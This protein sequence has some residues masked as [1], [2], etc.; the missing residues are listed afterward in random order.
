MSGL[1]LFNFFV[2]PYDL[3]RLVLIPGINS[4]KHET[5]RHDRM[6]KTFYVRTQEPSA[7]AL[8]SSRTAIGI[9]PKH[10]GWDPRFRPPYNYGLG[11]CSMAELVER[12]ENMLRFQKVDQL[13]V[14]LDFF[15]FN[16]YARNAYAVEPFDDSSLWWLDTL[17]S[18]LLTVEAITSSVNTLRKQD[19]V[20]APGYLPDGQMAWTFNDER[21]AEM[22]HR[23][24]FLRTERFYFDTTYF[25]GE[26]KKYTF[27][28]EESGRPT[29]FES[30]R[31]LLALAHE[32]K[33]DLKLYMSPIHAHMNEVIIQSGLWQKFEDWK[34]RVVEI[35]DDE[36]RSAHD[37]TPYVLWDF[38]GY[39][40]VTTEEVPPFG[41]TTT[42]MKYYWE[43]S[44]FKTATGDL[45]MSTVFDYKETLAEVPE[46]FGVLIDEGNIERHLMNI[47]KDQKRYRA[48]H[49]KD[50]EQIIDLK[51]DLKY[52]PAGPV[53]I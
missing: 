14:G 9:D 53:D 12:L 43:P 26:N 46:D 13:L 10:P 41:D 37:S 7:L 2:D 11:G 18:S 30:F 32:N 19:P 6:T 50:I 44:H 8:G 21:V 45:I 36:N 51:K 27:F 17:N 48:S 39:S 34:R 4:N 47:R 25:P 31:R 24:S 38:S 52:V 5:T 23:Q 22:G 28:S 49:Q 29:Q 35:L 20:R 40:S 1:V 16:T 3:Y 33:I 15:A 42:H